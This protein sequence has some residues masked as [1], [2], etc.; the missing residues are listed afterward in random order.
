MK[1]CHK[2]LKWVQPFTTKVDLIKWP[3]S[4]CHS[5]FDLNEVKSQ[6]MTT[7]GY[8]NEDVS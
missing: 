2:E 8:D 3:V 4:V 1:V 7:S 6:Q 5:L